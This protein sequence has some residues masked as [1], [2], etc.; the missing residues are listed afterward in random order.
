MAAQ[1]P[2]EDKRHDE[3]GVSLE[4]GSIGNREGAAREDLRQFLECGSDFRSGD[5]LIWKGARK[6]PPKK[7]RDCD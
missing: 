5:Q 4:H 1:R 3:S 2:E 6:V 7:E